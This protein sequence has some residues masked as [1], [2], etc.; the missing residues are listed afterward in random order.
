MKKT[1]IVL[2]ACLLLAA[3]SKVTLENYNKL[4]MGQSYE[5]TV[6]LLGDPARCDEVIGV[7]QCLWGSEEKGVSVNFVAGKVV[8]FAARNLK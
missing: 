2:A 5:Q 7:R 8:L 3:C 4:E 1:L 6:T